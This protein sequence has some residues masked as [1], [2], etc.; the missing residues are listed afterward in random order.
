MKVVSS[1][2]EEKYEQIKLCLQTEKSKAAL[3]QF[4]LNRRKVALQR[5]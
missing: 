1:E 4:N 2:S 3:L 5:M